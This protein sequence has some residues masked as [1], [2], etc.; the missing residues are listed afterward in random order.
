MYLVVPFLVLALVVGALVDIISRPEGQ[1]RH[2][3]KVG[4]IILVVIL[5][6]I[7]SIVWFVVGHDYSQ[8]AEYVSLGDPRRHESRPAATSTEQQLADLDAEIEFHN[9]QARIDR[10]EAEVAERRERSAE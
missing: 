2:L 1:V 5:P 7:G 9:K 4:W 8:R 10:L 3:P 6:L